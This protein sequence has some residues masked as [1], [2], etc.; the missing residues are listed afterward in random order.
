MS[1]KRAKESFD[2]FIELIKIPYYIIKWIIK[3]FDK[4]KKM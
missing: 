3:L 2:F 1:E 4:K